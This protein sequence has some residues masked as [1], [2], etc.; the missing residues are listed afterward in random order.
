MLIGFGGAALGAEPPAPGEVVASSWQHHKLTINYFGITAL[1]TC[2]GLEDH[3]KDILVHLGARPDAKV[4]A[5]GCPRGPDVPSRSAWIEADFYTLAPAADATAPDVVRAVWSAREISP[6]RPYYMDDGDC[7]L[8]DQMKDLISK[9]FTLK[10]VAFTASC[11]PH[12]LSPNSFHVKANALVA[13]P[14][15]KSARN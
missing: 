10:D 11:T 5:S 15:A 6:R 1:Y 14:E 3:V 4:R 13:L 2:Y 12:A 9:N 8:V 7:E